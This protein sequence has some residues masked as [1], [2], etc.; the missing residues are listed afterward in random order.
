MHRHRRLLAHLPRKRQRRRE[1][2]LDLHVD[3]DVPLAHPVALG[4]A[5]ADLVALASRALLV[6]HVLGVLLGDLP[7]RAADVFAR[8]ALVAVVWAPRDAPQ[9]GRGIG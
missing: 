3:G 2:Y 4:G 1:R 5:H 7:G 9:G 8:R 6:V